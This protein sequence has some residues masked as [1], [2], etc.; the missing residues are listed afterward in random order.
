MGTP[1]NAG[2]LYRVFLVVGAEGLEPPTCWL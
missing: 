1:V 2:L